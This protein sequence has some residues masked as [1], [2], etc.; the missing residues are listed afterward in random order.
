MP[1]V[2]SRMKTKSTPLTTSRFS[3][4]LPRRAGN[5]RVA[6]YDVNGRLVRTL[7]DGPMEAGTRT[8]AWDGTSDRG[9]RVPGGIYFIR[10]ECGG[11]IAA[12]RLAILR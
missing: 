4:E 11:R 8:L 10:L 6:A 9:A 2:S 1:P 5:A 7:W 12:R 3:V